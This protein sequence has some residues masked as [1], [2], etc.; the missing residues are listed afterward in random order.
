MLGKEKEIKKKIINSMV[1]LV[2][3]KNTH[4]YIH[5]SFLSMSRD[6]RG[7]GKN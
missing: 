1:S 3:V 6:W 2:S 7:R 5:K 4:T